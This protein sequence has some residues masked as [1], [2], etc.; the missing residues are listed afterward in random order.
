MKSRF[1][2]FVFLLLCLTGLNA[3]TGFFNRQGVPLKPQSPLFGKDIL[4]QDQ[5][6]R[7][8]RNVAICSAFNG[9]LYAVYSYPIGIVQAISVLKSTDNGINWE[10]LGE[11]GMTTA[12]FTN[13][14][15]IVACGTGIDNIK[16]FV[17]CVYLDTNTNT[18][19]GL[20]IRYNAD[21]FAYEDELLKDEGGQIKDLALSSDFMY[22]STNASPFSLGVLLAKG[23]IKDSIMF[24][25]SSNGGI[26]LN[27]PRIVTTTTKYLHRVSLNYGRSPLWSDG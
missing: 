22:P 19:W 26:S 5:P 25:S 16:I 10:L 2:L 18:R 4:I 6:D 20:V 23:G 9:W 24:L 15:D 1:T 8:Q 12:S 17:G 21:P 14:L 11:G 13:K 7:D 3:Q 27:S